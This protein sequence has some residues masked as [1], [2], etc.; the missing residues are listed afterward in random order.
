M[1]Q[2]TCDTCCFRVQSEC[3]RF[4]PQ[5]SILPLPVQDLA[6]SQDRIQPTPVGAFPQVA[7][8]IWCGEYDS[9][10]QIQLN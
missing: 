3:R 2:G 5:V 9:K 4:P 8:E 1:S 10:K 6:H 7:P